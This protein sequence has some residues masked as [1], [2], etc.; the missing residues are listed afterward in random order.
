MLKQ[1]VGLKISA[2]LSK[3]VATVRCFDFISLV[4]SVCLLSF[5]TAFAGGGFGAKVIAGE[6]SRVFVDSDWVFLK[7]F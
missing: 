2:K 5:K 6:R 3:S 7:E 4:S 1:F